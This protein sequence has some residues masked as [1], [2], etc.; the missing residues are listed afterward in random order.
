MG[1]WIVPFANFSISSKLGR[2]N[3]FNYGIL[4]RSNKVRLVWDGSK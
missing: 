3:K 1:D 2:W 4:K